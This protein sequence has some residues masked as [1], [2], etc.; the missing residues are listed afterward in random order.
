MVC[1][2]CFEVFVLMRYLKSNRYLQ[3]GF[4][5]YLDNCDGL[6]LVKSSLESIAGPLGKVYLSRKPISELF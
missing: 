3:G 6:N 4:Q 2:V 5:N 1:I